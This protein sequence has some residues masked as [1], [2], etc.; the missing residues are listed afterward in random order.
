MR[1]GWMCRSWEGMWVFGVYYNNFL[2]Y[3]VSDNN[4]IIMT[5]V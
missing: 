4:I 5:E 1:V 3:N 2:E